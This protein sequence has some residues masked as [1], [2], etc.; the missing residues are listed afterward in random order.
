MLE[1]YAMILPIS[2]ES[3]LVQQSSYFTY[4]YTLINPVLPKVTDSTLL[5]S[6]LLYSMYLFVYAS[7]TEAWWDISL[8]AEL[9]SIGVVEAEHDAKG[10]HVLYASSLP[11]SPIKE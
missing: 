5:V 1:C 10:S 6:T 4:V 9:I 8:P 7:E 3:S 11:L 2:S